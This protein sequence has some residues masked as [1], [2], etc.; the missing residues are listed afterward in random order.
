MML[1]SVAKVR[2]TPFHEHPPLISGQHVYYTIVA[3]NAHLCGQS[4]YYTIP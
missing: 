3:R 1:I 4:A 2:T